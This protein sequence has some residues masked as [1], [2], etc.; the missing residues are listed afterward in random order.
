MVTLEASFNEN[1][2]VDDTLLWHDATGRYSSIAYNEL[3]LI[4]KCVNFVTLMIVAGSSPGA[5]NTHRD[6]SWSTHTVF[7]VPGTHPASYEI[8]LNDAWKFFV[9]VLPFAFMHSTFPI[10]QY[11]CYLSLSW[12][13][14]L[15]KFIL[16]FRFHVER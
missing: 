13:R 9:I 4:L 7:P 3:S 2:N 11:S 12:S 10:F 1:E 16:D 5:H 15:N 8:S 14:F 6:Q